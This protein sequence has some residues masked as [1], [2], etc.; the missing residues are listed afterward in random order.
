VFVEWDTEGQ[1]FCSFLGLFYDSGLFSFHIGV[2][3]TN[4]TYA[5][6]PQGGACA[7]AKN[8]PVGQTATCGVGTVYKA[9]PCSPQFLHLYFVYYNTGGGPHCLGIGPAIGSSLPG[10]CD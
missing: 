3:E 4:Y 9:T 8:C 1:V 10:N 5:P 7:Y 2:S 6:P